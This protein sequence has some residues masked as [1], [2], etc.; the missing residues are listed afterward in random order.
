MEALKKLP[1][2]T[3]EQVERQFAATV[4]WRKENITKCEWHPKYKGDVP[5]DDMECHGCLDVFCAQSPEK[6]QEWEESR[7]IIDNRP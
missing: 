3:L 4:K 1:P 2:P 7:V 5:P 6:F